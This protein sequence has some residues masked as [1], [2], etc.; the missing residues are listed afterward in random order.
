MLGLEEFLFLC[1][2][3]IVRRQQRRIYLPRSQD[4]EHTFK[5]EAEDSNPALHIQCV[6]YVQSGPDSGIQG[7]AER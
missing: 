7:E 5:E 6:R 3:L 2:V 1:F 4:V